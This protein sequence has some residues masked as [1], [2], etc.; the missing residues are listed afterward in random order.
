MTPTWPA[1]PLSLKLPNGY[2]FQQVNYVI[3]CCQHAVCN[4]DS[5]KASVDLFCQGFFISAGTPPLTIPMSLAWQPLGMHSSA[6]VIPLSE[7]QH[8]E[9]QNPITLT[10][11]PTDILSD[12]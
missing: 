11:C 3:V 1:T 12:I 6:Y 8:H 4:C 7:S 9:I 2:I 10:L 5:K